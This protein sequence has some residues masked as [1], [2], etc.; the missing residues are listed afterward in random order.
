MF[1]KRLKEAK[2]RDCHGDLRTDHIYFTDEGIQI[3]DCIEFNQRFRFS[4]ITADLAF[5]SMDLD[6]NGFKDVGKVLCV[7]MTI[8]RYFPH[9]SR[10][11]F[12]TALSFPPG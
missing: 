5:L 3:I 10:I 8:L 6:F 2:I 4:D 1:E 12:R 11:S 9:C 7:A